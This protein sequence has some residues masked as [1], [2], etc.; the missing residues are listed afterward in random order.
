MA[1]EILSRSLVS[2]RD[3]SFE[4][5][6]NGLKHFKKEIYGGYLIT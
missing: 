2:S 3:L 4:E 1:H 5:S 6:M